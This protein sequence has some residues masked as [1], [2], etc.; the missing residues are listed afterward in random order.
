MSTSPNLQPWTQQSTYDYFHDSPQIDA[1]YKYLYEQTHTRHNKAVVLATLTTML[2]QLD[3]PVSAIRT[4]YFMWK[5][6]LLDNLWILRHLINAGLDPN[7]QI[8]YGSSQTLIEY[9]ACSNTQALEL[10]LR[11]G[12]NPF[13]NVGGEPPMLHQ[14]VMSTYI[15]RI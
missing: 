6:L 4:L 3:H 11:A 2:Q 12:A 13:S 5:H 10:L 7:V 14:A 1:I 8:S 15:H 9:A